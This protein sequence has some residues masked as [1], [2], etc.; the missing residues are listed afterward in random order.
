MIYD[1]DGVE[2][3]KQIVRVVFI[4]IIIYHTGKTKHPK[5]DFRYL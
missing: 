1:V 2:R 5:K 4:I 3:W